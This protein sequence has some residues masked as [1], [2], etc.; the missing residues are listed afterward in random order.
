MVFPYIWVNYHISLTWILRPPLSFRTQLPGPWD[1]NLAASYGDD[2]PIKTMIPGLGRT[3]FGRYNLPIYI[4]NNSYIYHKPYLSHKKKAT[5]N[6]NSPGGPLIDV[7]S[8]GIFRGISH[9]FSPP[10]TCAPPPEAETY[11]RCRRT[12]MATFW[13]FPWRCLP[14]KMCGDKRWKFMVNS[15]AI[16]FFYE[17]WW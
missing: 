4:Y 9:R 1:L 5:K 2:F 17:R 12:A 11:L 16:P 15:W 10:P 7:F 3:G 8:H 14:K 6:A 13:G